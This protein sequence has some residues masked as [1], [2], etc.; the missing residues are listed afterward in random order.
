MKTVLMNIINGF[1]PQN[2]T[3]VP[4]IP[5]LAQQIEQARQEWLSAQ[6]YYNN[7]SD[8]DLVDHAT[9]LIHAAE[10]KY[11]YLLKRARYEGVRY[12]PFN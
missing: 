11:T 3:I 10:K 1:I 8:V 7:V 5:P 2:V 4:R 6:N 9:F 12:A